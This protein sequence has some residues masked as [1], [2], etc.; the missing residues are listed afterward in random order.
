M[1]RANHDYH[2]RGAIAYL[3]AYDVHRAK[4]HGRVADIVDLLLFPERV[5]R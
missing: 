3:A 1:M 5:S 2:R 4:I